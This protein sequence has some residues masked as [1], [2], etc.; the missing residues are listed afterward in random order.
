MAVSNARV[1]PGFLTPVLRQR[2][3]FFFFPKMFTTTF[4]TCLRKERRKYA[5]KKVCF[6]Q[7]SNSS[8]EVMNRTHSPLRVCITYLDIH[9]HLTFSPENPVT[10]LPCKTPLK[11]ENRAFNMPWN[12]VY[13]NRFHIYAF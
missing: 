3:F 12:T 13:E 2:V 5:R 7:V 11:K 8:E 9:L 1:F 6:N 4:L 10:D